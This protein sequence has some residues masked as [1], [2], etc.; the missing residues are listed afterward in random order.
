MVELPSA[1]YVQSCGSVRD[2]GALT[3][4]GGLRTGG[5]VVNGWLRDSPGLTRLG[6]WG[7]LWRERL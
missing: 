3:S 2:M 1:T 7:A 6:L 5:A 4:G